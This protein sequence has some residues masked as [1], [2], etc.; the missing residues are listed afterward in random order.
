MGLLTGSLVGLVNG[1]LAV[2]AR[3]PA[4][5]VTLG[6]MYI[7]R[8]LNYLLCGGNPIYPLPE[9]LNA[10]G[11]DSPLGISWAF[12]VFVAVAVV[13]QLTLS[14]TVFGRA[15]YATG[16][17]CEVARIA[18]IHTDAVK[19]ICYILTATLAALAGILLM[20]QLNVG[21]PE[22]GSGWELEVIASVVIGG[23][24]LFGGMGTVTGTALGLLLMQVVRNG[25]VMSRVNT[26]WQTVAVGCV[27]IAAVGLD[28]VRRRAKRI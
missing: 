4:F 16:G 24:S 22:N 26:H 15:I 11:T 27:M 9:A 3:I 23:V 17:N 21:Q 12:F 5:I 28:L 8:G 13:G 2:R 6:M 7:A 1:L 20:A 14:K 19:I 18:G 10:I 25:L